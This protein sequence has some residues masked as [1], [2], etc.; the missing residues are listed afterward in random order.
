MA[1]HSEQNVPNEA[2]NLLKLKTDDFPTRLK[3]VN[4]LKISWLKLVIQFWM[5]TTSHMLRNL[6]FDWHHA[7]CLY[8]AQVKACEDWSKK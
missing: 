6:S 1:E 7:I 2:V 4:I 8:L 5:D 3:A